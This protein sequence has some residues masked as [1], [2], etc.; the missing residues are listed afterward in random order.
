M[1]DTFA[2]PGTQ[3][4]H[5]NGSTPAKDSVAPDIGRT[6]LVGLLGGI[7]SAA[8]YVVYQRLPDDQRQRLHTQ[9]RAFAEERLGDFKQY[10]SS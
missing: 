8:G 9:L 3:P 2:R 6:L 10:F 5:P 7:V 1:A 4:E